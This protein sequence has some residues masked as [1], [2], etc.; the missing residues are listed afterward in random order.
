[1]S[2][3]ER[4]NQLRLLHC[5]LLHQALCARPTQ[6]RHQVNKGHRRGQR[7][8]RVELVTQQHQMVGHVHAVVVMDRCDTDTYITTC[9]WVRTDD[10]AASDGGQC[11]CSRCDGQLRH[12]YIHNE[13]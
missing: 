6:L 12:R 4:L 1:M 10:P 2:G 7:S 9:N 3:V 8:R 13:M 5:Q 11:T